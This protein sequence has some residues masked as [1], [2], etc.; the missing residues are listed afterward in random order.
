MSSDSIW[1]T[2]LGVYINA[3]EHGEQQ[4]KDAA[5]AEL[6]LIADHLHALGVKYP[7]VEQVC[8]PDPKEW[9]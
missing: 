5:A 8:R 3:L 6:M 9:R 4:A 7:H 1:K 2:T